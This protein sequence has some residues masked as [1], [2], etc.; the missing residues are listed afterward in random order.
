MVTKEE[1]LEELKIV[2]DPE[3][4]MDIVNLGLI[5]EVDVNE[6]KILIKMTMTAP[7]C[8]VTPWILAEVQKV[9][10][11]MPGVEMADVEL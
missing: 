1:I 2:E 10:E 7:T 11:N 9:V 8:P 5:Y 4:G 3:I 6:D